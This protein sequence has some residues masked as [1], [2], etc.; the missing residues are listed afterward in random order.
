V[1]QAARKFGHIVDKLTLATR[2]GRAA[3]R[4]R[5]G[6]LTNDLSYYRRRASEERTAA[7]NSRDARVRGVHSELAERYEERVRGMA[8]HHEALYFPMV[9]Q[10]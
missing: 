9:E 8:A 2:V 5:G 1:I 4:R 3:I 10:V 6:A 7:L